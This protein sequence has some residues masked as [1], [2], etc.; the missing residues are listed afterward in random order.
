M[1]VPYLPA[2]T[3]RS[4]SSTSEYGDRGGAR[5]SVRPH[6]RTSRSSRVKPERF[7]SGPG[8]SSGSNSGPFKTE[9]NRKIVI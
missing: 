6:S 9:K 2:D 1:P 8:S 3:T 4:V 5:V 7:S